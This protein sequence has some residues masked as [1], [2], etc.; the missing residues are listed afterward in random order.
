MSGDIDH[1]VDKIVGEI[2]IKGDH[3]SRVANDASD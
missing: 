2:E 1:I 3:T